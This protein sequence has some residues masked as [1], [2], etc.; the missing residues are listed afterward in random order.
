MSMNIEFVGYRDV[1]VL[2]TGKT[3]VQNNSFSTWQTPTAVSLA[4]MKAEDPFQA[5]RDWVLE[6]SED[7]IIEV[8]ADDDVFCEGEATPEVYNAGKEHIERF[9][10]YLEGSAELGFDVRVELC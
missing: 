5:Y 2:R 9:N 8:F 10:K 6:N 1:M 3:E 4:I 7:E